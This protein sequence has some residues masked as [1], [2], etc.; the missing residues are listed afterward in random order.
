MG[1][2]MINMLNAVQ[3]NTVTRWRL[4]AVPQCSYSV[5]IQLREWL[6]DAIGGIAWLAFDN[7]GQSP[8]I[9]IFC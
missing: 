2:D 9:P 1:T 6:P 4:V 3:P 7:P 5:V 8:R